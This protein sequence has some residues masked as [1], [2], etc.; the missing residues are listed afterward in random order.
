MRKGNYFLLVFLAFCMG[1]EDET[2]IET[3]GQWE[4]YEIS[5]TA[6]GSYQNPYVDVDL[7]AVFTDENGESYKR[8]AFWDGENNWKIRF[9]PPEADHTYSWETFANV[10]DNGLDGK[11]GKVFSSPYRGENELLQKGFLTLSEGKRNVVHRDGSPFLLVGD[12]PWALPF[13]G[14]TSSVSTYAK[15]RQ[16]KGFNAA[17]LMTVQPDQGVEGPDSREEDGGFGR[18]FHD[19]KDGHLNDLNPAYFQLLDELLDI[20]HAHE[21]VPVLQPV[22]QGYGWKGKNALG[23]NPVP[24]E[25]V[26]YTKYLLARYGAMPV[27]YLVSADGHGKEPGI[28]ETGEMLMEWDAYA[29]P[30]GI[31]YNPF[32]E[33]PPTGYTGDPD[34]FPKHGNKS[35]QEEE[36]LDF[37]WCQ[38]GHA[39][40][41]ILHKVERM[42]HNSPTKAVA[43]GEPTYERIGDPDKATGWWQGH[44][45]W[46]QW[47]SGGT[48]GV[49]YGAAG[50]WNWKLRTEEPDFA[51][52]STTNASWE[53]ATQ[54]EGSVYPGILGK[55]LE[56]YDIADIEISDQEASGAKVLQKENS[57]FV[58]YL[59][60]GGDLTLMGIKENLPVVFVDPKTGDSN[61]QDPT[62]GEVKQTFSLPD[63]EPWVVLIGEKK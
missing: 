43:N 12:T 14:T 35:Y 25:Y 60:K 41:H 37:Q 19:L 31:H 8:P 17:L 45:A 36:W 58:A 7:F 5:L 56:G 2:F 39:G 22:F 21:I 32:D 16:E 23:K 40:E 38:T 9:A 11:M 18:G 54:F 63:D 10:K 33:A 47:T 27:M 30:R 6:D 42:Y 15:D 61:S 59:P 29:Q 62:T 20:L 57:L 46:S 53:E 44:E 48:M 3:V 49:V 51:D 34:N 50:L 26:R 52:W 55:T 28:K 13:R 4:R 24:E 1:C